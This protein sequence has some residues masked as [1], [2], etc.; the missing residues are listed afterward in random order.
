MN[1]YELEALILADI[2]T[3]NKIYKV[4]IKIK[5]NVMYQKEPKEFLKLKTKGCRK[6]YFESD[7]P[8][9]FKRL[10]FNKIGSNCKYFSDF[11]AEFK[12]TAKLK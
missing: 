4:D 8:D 5:G 9:L 3:F 6:K 11:I 7:C 1:I 12:K 10:R 2:E